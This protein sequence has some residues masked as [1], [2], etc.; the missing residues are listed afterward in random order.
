MPVFR[1]SKSHFSI[2]SCA[3]EESS[4]MSKQSSVSLIELLFPVSTT[5]YE[6]LATPPAT[7]VS[8]HGKCAKLRE[9]NGA[10]SSKTCANSESPPRKRPNGSPATVVDLRKGA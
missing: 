7:T 3:T 9:K 10:K 4:K 8:G 6:L 1:P 2:R 5:F